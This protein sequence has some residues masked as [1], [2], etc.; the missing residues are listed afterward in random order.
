MMQIGLI[1]LAAGAA[2]ALLFASFASG[3]LLSVPLFYL[4]PLPILLA[5]LGWNHVAALIA[6]A[7][8]ALAL[9]IYFGTTFFVV[10]FLVGVGLPAWWLGYLAL[11]GRPDAA[12]DIEWYPAGRLVIWAAALAAMVVIFVI[13]SIASDAEELRRILRK[14]FEP[15]LNDPQLST[16][17]DGSAR[18]FTQV[19][20]A[21]PDLFLPPVAAVL[22]TLV[23]VFCL[24][25]AGRIT[26][27]SN[28][29][30]RP[31]PD[32]SSLEFPPTVLFAL[33]LAFAGA[34]LLSDMPRVIAA[35]FTTAL[36]TAMAML[37]LAVLH[38]VT[39]PLGARGLVLGG[40][41][42][43]L[44]M[45]GW[46]ILLAAMLGLADMALDFRGRNKAP[47]TTNV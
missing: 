19:L 21:S 36:L 4:S 6:A 10:G 38:S 42:V 15:L 20:L 23:T 26:R 5:A 37:G 17:P 29:L 7:I 28:R 1:G 12:G 2:S 27:A 16:R 11:L 46:P 9:G 8:A 32:L 44:F 41:Y 33:A 40:T 35:I 14:S 47:P 45:F 24:W 18:R 31:W 39:R 3:S 34:F 22:T 13:F 43:F 30:R 25:L